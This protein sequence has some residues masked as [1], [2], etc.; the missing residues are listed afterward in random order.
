MKKLL[1]AVCFV[2]A[3]FTQLG[4]QATSLNETFETFNVSDGFPQK[5]WQVKSGTYPEPI[6]RLKQSNDGTNKYISFYS[7]ESP[8]KPV[9]LFT[10]QVVASD[11]NYKVKFSTLG[12]GQGD[13][14]VTVCLLKEID[15]L[16]DVIE[17]KTFNVVPNSVKNIVTIPKTDRQYIAFK[18]QASQAH[19]ACGLDNVEYDKES[20]STIEVDN[21]NHL[22]SI[23]TTPDQN[24]LYFI[25]RE[26]TV[27][28]VNIFSANGQ[29]VLNAKPNNNKINISYLSTGAYIVSATLAN[30][31]TVNTKFIKK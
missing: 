16:D 11:G 29:I 13:I 1:S 27:D 19:G 28:Q 21:M 3:I 18:F 4:A 22:V 24:S 10:P 12:N 20:L 23:A 14:T 8:N 31:K 7:A 9:Y 25:T 15:N 2:L 30:G 6:I 5:G 17:V 26:S